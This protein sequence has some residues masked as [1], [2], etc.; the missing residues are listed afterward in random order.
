MCSKLVQLPFH[1]IRRTLAADSIKRRVNRCSPIVEKVTNIGIVAHVDAGKT[2]MTERMLF[3]CGSIRVMGDVDNGDTIT[4]CLSEERERGISIQSAAVR[5]SWKKNIINLID[6]P[7]HVDFM[8]EVQRSLM[9]LESVIVVV[10]STAGVQAQT[11]TVWNQA[12]DKSKIVFL[13]KIDLLGDQVMRG[14]TACMQSLEEAF[15][16]RNDLME[17]NESP[18]LRTQMIDRL[19]Q[20]DDELSSRIIQGSLE[21]A[22]CSDETCQM[23]RSTLKTQVLKR[24]SY[25]VL[26]GS[27]MNNIGVSQ[28]LDAVCHYFPLNN[29]VDHILEGSPRFRVFKIKHLHRD[30]FG[31]FARVEGNVKRFPKKY[32][33]LQLISHYYKRRLTLS[34][35]YFPYSDEL[36]PIN[37]TISSGD[38]VVLD[39]GEW[40]K[41]IRVGDVLSLSGAHIPEET[42]VSSR[43]H[44]VFMCS[45]EPMASGDASKLSNA[46]KILTTEDDSVELNI[47]DDQFILYRIHVDSYLGF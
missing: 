44:P 40:S 19:A 34:Q 31:L 36:E 13:N 22:D 26:I 37:S 28:L 11:R 39:V 29:E 33:N 9:A 7:G 30:T 24:K 15:Y 5:M 20:N 6:T 27:A 38:I 1:Y 10:D 21:Y 2:T 46:L 17:N 32:K 45:I 8:M 3:N 14:V 35:M 25:P 12:K 23:L 43:T 42:V 18:L 4:D 16:V 41:L 47:E